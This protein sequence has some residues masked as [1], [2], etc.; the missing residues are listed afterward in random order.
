MLER[1]ALGGAETAVLRMARALRALGHEVQVEQLPDRLEALKGVDVLVL[2]R[3]TFALDPPLARRTYF[4]SPDDIVQPWWKQ[5]ADDAVYR[6]RFLSSLTG[7]FALS[8]YQAQR[9]MAIGIP[10]Q[11]I[12]ITRNGIDLRLFEGLPAPADDRRPPRC[13]YTSVPSR[14]L[15]VLL[16]LWPEIRRQVPDA[17]LQIFSSMKLYRRDEQQGEADPE[18]QALYER[19]QSLP[20]V[21]YVGSVPQP[22]LAA[23]LKQA[24]LLLY[25]VTVAE[26]SCIAALEA[27][28][29]GCAVVTSHF[30]ALPETAWGNSFVFGSP[31]SVGYQ[32]LFAQRAA[33][34]LRND[35]LWQQISEQNRERMGA[36]SWLNVARQWLSIFEAAQGG[37]P[38]AEGNSA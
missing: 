7:V 10:Q 15:D 12:T 29:A 19:A 1:R 28:A 35:S 25:P 18:H 31:Y 33:E 30:G 36:Y 37:A 3:D 13:V 5:V 21:E 22:Q 8:H 16:Q 34:L 20:G 32:R 4:W 6:E 14:G 23:A 38:Q 26:I 11:Q 9:M 17:E 24:K 2:K 27:Q